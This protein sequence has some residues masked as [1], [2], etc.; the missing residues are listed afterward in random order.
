LIEL[1]TELRDENGRDREV[2]AAVATLIGSRTAADWAEV[3]AGEDVCVTVVA[4]FEEAA[5]AMRFGLDSP[6][7]LVGEGFD[8]AALPIPLSPEVR[9]PPTERTYPLLDGCL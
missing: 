2:T 8:V 5:A 7:R 1:Q 4:S 3:F 9:V 6:H